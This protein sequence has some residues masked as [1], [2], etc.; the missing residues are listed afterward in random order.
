MSDAIS[1]IDLLTA[2]INLVFAYISM[3]GFK[4]PKNVVKVSLKLSK[5]KNKRK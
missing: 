2:L 4:K 1:Y 5:K 3:R